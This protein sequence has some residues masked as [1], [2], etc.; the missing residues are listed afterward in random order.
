MVNYNTKYLKYISKYIELKGGKYLSKGVDGFVYRPPLFCDDRDAK[1]NSEDYVGKVMVKEKA[2]DE[3]MKSNLI[4]ELDPEGHWSITIDKIC[5]INDQQTD[6]DY[7]KNKNNELYKGNNFQL[8]S[9]YGGVSLGKGLLEFDDAFKRD[10]VPTNIP[11]FF[12]LLKTQLVPIIIHL[13]KIYAHNDLHLDNILYNPVDKRIRIFDFAKLMPIA[14]KKGHRMSN[15]DF[16]DLHLYLDPV[17]RSIVMKKWFEQEMNAYMEKRKTILI[18]PNQ[19][20][21]FSTEQYIEA[22]LALPDL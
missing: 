14:D 18:N 20:G 1:Y 10:D 19:E 15:S 16:E 13:N 12:N 5:K 3:F 21:G 22:I 4:K 17:I 11:L 2:E 9:K 7:L 8:I 6:E